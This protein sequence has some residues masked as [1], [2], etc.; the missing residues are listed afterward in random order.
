MAGTGHAAKV[1]A[2]AAMGGGRRFVLDISAWAAKAEADVN[3]VLRGVAMELGARLVARTPVD[4][5]RAKANWRGAAGRPDT[6][7][8]Q[9]E[10]KLSVS[11]ATGIAVSNVTGAAG[12]WNA[13]EHK[14]FYVTNALPYMRRLEY[15]WSVQA[16]AGMVRVTLV[17]FGK[18][19][20]EKV[21]IVRRAK[22]AS[23]P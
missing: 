6:T 20:G 11:T 7:A 1:D 8:I 16:P 10:G 4:T 19:V 17:E 2:K 13:R 3:T 9:G 15:G 18:I 23:L 5:G 14:S 21:R 22:R 12:K